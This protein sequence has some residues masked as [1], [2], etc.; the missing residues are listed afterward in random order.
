MKK[1]LL[2]L[3]IASAGLAVK[4][5][6]TGI[7]FGVKAG[8]TFPTLSYSSDLEEGMK[9]KANTSF[10]VG[11]TVDIPVGGMFTIQPGLTFSGKGDKQEA[12]VSE[13]GDSFS[14]KSSTSLMYIEIPVNAVV[15]FP[16]GEGKVF[17]GAGPYYGMAISG[18]SKMESKMTVD[19]VTVS[20]EESNDADF[21]K[22]GD[23]KRSDFGVN[24]LG[25]YQLSNGFN[26]HAGY[27]LGLSNIAKNSGDLKVKNNVLSVGVG[28]SF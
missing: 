2:S 1:I 9:N 4:A 22:D 26:I 15:S 28:F 21:G 20:D 17:V 10:Y 3:M 19:G 24:F 13:G 8:V 27:G 18:K 14:A 11:G 23:T 16:V 5:Q 6:E 25:G 12:S 7:K